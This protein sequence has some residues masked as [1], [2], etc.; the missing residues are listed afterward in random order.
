M[1]TVA[2]QFPLF[3]EVL[4]FCIQVCDGSTRACFCSLAW[5]EELFLLTDSY[6]GGVARK[7][8]AEKVWT[9]TELHPNMPIP[10]HTE[11]LGLQL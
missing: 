8:V 7:K 1:L 3:C 9:S 5:A 2:L 10:G 6:L 4:S 11:L